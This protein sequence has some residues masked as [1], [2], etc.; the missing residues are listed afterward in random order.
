MRLFLRLICILA[1]TSAPVWADPFTITVTR[2]GTCAVLSDCQ[3]TFTGDGSLTFSVPRLGEFPDGIFSASGTVTET[4]TAGSIFLSLTNLTVQGLGGGITSPPAIPGGI[5]IVSG[6]RIVSLDGVSGF[7]SL[8]GQYQTN[9]GTGIIGY[10]E[11]NLRAQIGGLT[12]G[13][14]DAGV[15][16]GVPSPVPFSIFN[17]RSFPDIPVANK[18]IGTLNFDVAPGDGFFLPGSADVFAQPV[19]EPSTL[20]LL[21]STLIGIAALK[22]HRSR[23]L[24]S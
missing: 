24:N 3:Q 21:G 1:F 14:V 22:V 5:E 12:V 16:T 10:D 7:A 6:G 13:F 19:P 18:L 9:S 17:A 4:D 23:K 11:L 2:F 15:V 20:F 8:N